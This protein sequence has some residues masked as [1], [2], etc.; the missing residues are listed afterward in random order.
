[1]LGR[2]AHLRYVHRVDG[3]FR[4]EHALVR[5]VAY[6]RLPGNTR[7]RLHARY[8]REGLD[9]DQAEA[10]AHH[11]WEALGTSDAEWI[12]EGE[13]EIETMRGEALRAHL[14][15][16]LS[17]ADRMALDRAFE[18]Y[19]RALKLARDPRNS[20]PGC[21]GRA[22]RRSCH[23]RGSTAPVCIS[24]R[25]AANETQLP[26]TTGIG[27]SAQRRLRSSPALRDR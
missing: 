9:P 14:D 12:W 2:L 4:F 7:A 23:G 21:S 27:S 15:A 8:A 18:V 26:T 16:G 11:W 1:M 25:A 10:L 22:Q 17:L 13:P 5:D 24:S 20:Q 19:E 3:A 6:A